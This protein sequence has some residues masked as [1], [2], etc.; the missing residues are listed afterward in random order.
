[1]KALC[2]QIDALRMPPAFGAQ[3]ADAVLTFVILIILFS[4]IAG[5]AWVFVKVL[6]RREARRGVI[7]RAVR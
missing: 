3:L 4:F 2:N 6:E 5:I 7:G 1:M